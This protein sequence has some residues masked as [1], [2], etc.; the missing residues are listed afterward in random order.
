MKKRIEKDD[1]LSTKENIFNCLTDSKF[2]YGMFIRQKINRL[3]PITFNTNRTN[4]LN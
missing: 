3:Y 2:T 4:I 1:K